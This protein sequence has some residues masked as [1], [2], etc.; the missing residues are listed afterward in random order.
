MSKRE[1]NKKVR[2]E[3]A[4]INLYAVVCY[5][6]VAVILT[7]AYAI[8]TFGKNAR[9]VEYF[10][11]TLLLA[12]VPA[13]SAVVL[14][15]KNSE[16][17]IVKHVILYG[18]LVFYGFLLFTATTPLT[19]TYIVLMIVIS[20]IYNDKKFAIQLSVIAVVMNVIQVII[21]ANTNS[22][23]YINLAGAEIQIILLVMLGGFSVSQSSILSKNNN[24][25]LDLIRVQQ[26]KSDELYQSTIETVGVMTDNINQIY[27]KLEELIKSSEFTRS[28]MKNVSNGSNET[29]IA[30]QNQMVQTEQVRK[31]LDMVNAS[32]NELTNEMNVAKNEIELGRDNMNKMVD[33]V[34]TTVVGGDEVTTEL[35][36]LDKKINEM[37]SIIEII[38]NITEQTSLVALNASIEA[39]R[40]GEAGRGFAVVASEISSMAEQTTQATEHITNLVHNVSQAIE[41]VVTQ[42]RSMIENV[43]V[44]KSITDTTK[45]SFTQMANSTTAMD[46]NIIEL[47]EILRGLTK[48]NKGIIESIQT[49]SAVS[50]EV[51][52]HASETYRAEEE[53]AEKIQE[54]W[55]L[56]TELKD[57]TEKLSEE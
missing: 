20:A 36:E 1:E 14:Y 24:D 56:M 8:E 5:M 25:K 55:N 35:G 23:A 45:T 43:N 15:R 17:K 57:L 6:I 50:E 28:A 42:V 10:I 3:M 7:A 40:A 30:V 16:S 2:T 31:Y 27:E 22:G 54:V 9:S 34:T 47:A 32:T 4:R 18:Y 21:A 12:M 52:A 19:F 46:D 37:N 49:I 48:A 53:N 44:E 39:A 11:V 51:T 26:K 41:K 38:T 33:S 29:S 13:I